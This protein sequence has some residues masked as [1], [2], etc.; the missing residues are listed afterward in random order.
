MEERIDL[1]ELS[2]QLLL[3]PAKIDPT[4]GLI[5]NVM[6]ANKDAFSRM[7]ILDLSKTVL[8]KNNLEKAI[9]PEL[10][11]D[12]KLDLAVLA[13]ERE[14]TEELRKSNRLP[15]GEVSTY[16]LQRYNDPNILYNPNVDM[17]EVYAAAHPASLGKAVQKAYHTGKSTLLYGLENT[18]NNIKRI[19]SLEMPSLFGNEE[20]K[21]MANAFLNAEM[22]YPMYYSKEDGELKKLALDLVAASGS[23]ISSVI[24]GLASSALI[25]LVGSAVGAPELGL[26]GLASK[27]KTAANFKKAI[28]GM[29]QAAN[30]LATARQMKGLSQ[31][32]RTG[33]TTF[34]SITGE[35]ALQAELNKRD[36]LDKSIQDFRTKNGRL[37]SDKE[38]T[39]IKNVASQVENSTYGQNLIL[40]GASTLLQLPALMKGKV[41]NSFNP[42]SLFKVVNG[43]ATPRSLKK[44]VGKEFATDFFSEAGEEYFQSVIDSA[45]QEYFKK[46]LDGDTRNYMESFLKS[47]IEVANKG[48]LREAL[49]GGLLG[50]GMSL[51]KT[52]PSAY[53]AKDQRSKAIDSFNKNTETVLDYL[54]NDAF[55]NKKMNSLSNPRDLNEVMDEKVVNIA[56]TSKKLGVEEN[57]RSYI[58]SLKSI[59]LDE[60]KDELGITEEITESFKNGIIDDMLTTFDHTIDVMRSAD[61]VFNVNPVVNEKWFDRAWKTVS[62]KTAGT[63]YD[64]ANVLYHNLKDIYVDAVIKNKTLDKRLEAIRSEVELGLDVD[65]LPF[66]PKVDDL[67]NKIL[68]DPN[69]LTKSI[70]DYESYLKDQAALPDTLENGKVLYTGSNKKLAE[71][72]DNLEDKNVYS[73]LVTILQHFRMSEDSA[74][75]IREYIQT[76]NAKKLFEDE[77]DDLSN[78]S[79][80]RDKYKEIAEYYDFIYK[81][82]EKQQQEDEKLKKEA[83]KK[84]AK[85]AEEETD[86]K[87][88]EKE[89]KPA[90]KT[91]AKPKAKAKA[92]T[93]ATTKAEVVTPKA[94]TK[95][96]TKAKAEVV[97]QK[98]KNVEVI[99]KTQK[100]AEQSLSDKAFVEKQIEAGRT[101]NFNDVLQQLKDSNLTKC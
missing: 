56:K 8:T 9:N 6:K 77:I 74:D 33:L 90:T 47:T 16:E 52:L 67:F 25:S 66:S 27:I 45:T 42:N 40:V 18:I 3:D 7:K 50:G 79:K 31:M 73:K 76:Y 97:A 34:L 93:K 64:Y 48:G 68:S 11:D 24:D 82:V 26:V 32:G 95:A 30:T 2:L 43:K 61:M 87:P 96:K 75:N 12:Q 37:P 59:P 14:R 36:F 99:T 63:K 58:E 80:Q 78:H 10:T 17:E 44:L 23:M 94:K 15:I 4:H 91:K 39:E 101:A 72:L 20:A 85:E 53:K 55:T 49:I 100:T 65:G 86:V 84:A 69:D 54:R 89:P 13:V 29:N 51:V 88:K 60:F 38:I 92:T 1:N 41:T 70:K 22:D 46:K 57:R 21:G 98:K 5:D 28:K 35:A 71:K 19:A 83:E 81:G 62:N